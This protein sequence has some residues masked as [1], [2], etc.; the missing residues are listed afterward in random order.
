MIGRRRQVSHRRLSAFLY[1]CRGPEN[2]ST[3]LKRKKNK[4]RFSEL[5][6]LR[7]AVGDRPSPFRQ[8]ITTHLFFN[9]KKYLE[10]V[11]VALFQS[12]FQILHLL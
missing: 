12:R 4:E 3:I 2:P 11:E 9:L 1:N 8:N 6:V 5:L 10:T 7:I